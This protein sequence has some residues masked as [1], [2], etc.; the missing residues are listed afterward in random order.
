VVSA[1]TSVTKTNVTPVTNAAVSSRDQ[2]LD[3]PVRR[4]SH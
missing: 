4:A 2:S 1:K 3:Q